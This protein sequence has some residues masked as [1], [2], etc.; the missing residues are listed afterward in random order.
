MKEKVTTFSFDNSKCLKKDKYMIILNDK[1]SNN[2]F[3]EILH[4]YESLLNIPYV[5]CPNCGSSK[6]IKWGYYSRNV[7][8]I[9]SNILK[10]KNITIKRVK[11]KG[12]GH[13]HALLP[14]FVIPYKIYLLDVIINSLI[15]KDVTLTI[16]YDVINKWNKQFNKFLPYL[17]TMLKKQ[18]KYLIIK[19][20][21]K[22][23]KYY[24]NLFFKSFR[25]ILMMIRHM[26][27]DMV[28]F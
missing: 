16:S 28:Y 17:K 18:D 6:L 24:Y 13:T 4:K 3:N 1:K 5:V 8:Y 11:C 19:T 27:I 20:F 14:S 23:I 7:C 12:C 10:N 9:D 26:I 21:L 25:K 15:N 22:D 2:F